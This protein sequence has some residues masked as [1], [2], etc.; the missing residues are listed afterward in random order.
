MPLFVHGKNY[1]SDQYLLSVIS[2]FFSSHF[3]AKPFTEFLLLKNTFNDLN[4]V[5]LR[6]QEQMDIKVYA[7]RI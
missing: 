1:S 4:D 2:A 6:V 3:G 5:N 7:Y